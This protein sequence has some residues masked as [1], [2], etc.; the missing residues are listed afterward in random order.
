M[1][2][3]I[4]LRGLRHIQGKPI[5]PM[6]DVVPGVHTCGARWR[7]ANYC[8]CA[9]CHLTFRS[10]RGFDRH[11]VALPGRRVTGSMARCLTEDELRRRGFEPDDEGIWRRPMTEA[12][13]S[14]LYR[15]QDV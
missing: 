4:N 2:D 8:H 7:G 1:T 14:R 12:E 15:N 5:E 13:S 11:R 10:V 6:G 9:T 3:R